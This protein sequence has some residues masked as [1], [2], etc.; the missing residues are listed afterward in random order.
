MISQWSNL[1]LPPEFAFDL[2]ANSQGIIS[3]GVGEPDFATP[4]HI[5]KASITAI[6]RGKLPY[7]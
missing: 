2:V 6:N 3:L 1:Y 4:Q 7:L 5:R